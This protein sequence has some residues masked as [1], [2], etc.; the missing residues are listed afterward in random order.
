MGRALQPGENVEWNSAP[1][2]V[3]GHG[4]NKPASQDD[5]QHAAQ[6]KTGKQAAG[7]RTP[8]KFRN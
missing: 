4:T 2:A 8:R 1:Q 6:D 5:P 3:P 7:K